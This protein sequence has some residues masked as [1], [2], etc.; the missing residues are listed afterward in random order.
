MQ[1]RDQ[2]DA[3]RA[4][5]F[6]WIFLRPGDSAGIADLLR[7]EEMGDVAPARAEPE[8]PAA[9]SEAQLERSREKARAACRA[10]S[11]AVAE[12]WALGD[13]DAGARVAKRLLARA[14]RLGAALAGMD[15]H[16]AEAVRLLRLFV[17]HASRMTRRQR[18][19]AAMLASAVPLAH[20]EAAD[21]LVEIARASDRLTAE[22][23]LEEAD[24]DPEV[25]DVDALVARLADVIDEGPTDDSR[26]IAIDLL[27]H[28][29]RRVATVPVLRRALR[30]QAFA[31]RSQALHAL[32]MAVPCAV[33][34]EDLVSILRDLVANAP[35]DV[36]AG[37]EAN[38]ERQEENE[39]MMADAVVAALAHVQPAE[40]EEALLD[41]ID[42]EHDAVW[43]DAGWA[44][45][46]LAAAFPETAAAMVDHWL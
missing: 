33:A 27:A 19:R 35:P 9:A 34:D 26:V 2:I 3:T 30:H 21:Y 25:G 31:V 14:D 40:A 29:E 10:L 37:H 44:T 45:E 36:L 28:L 7:A 1:R 43:L 17:R 41:L 12:A 4:K 42:A 23:L 46:A 18:E 38:Y 22:V 39:R 32:A 5:H 24:W 15:S 20:P 11:L 13:D 8:M 16:P 6:A